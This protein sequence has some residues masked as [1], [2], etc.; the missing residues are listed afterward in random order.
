MNSPDS[1]KPF[2]MSDDR[3]ADG[4][5]LE[6]ESH[7]HIKR[8]LRK[9]GQTGASELIVVMSQLARAGLVPATVAL[10][11]NCEIERCIRELADEDLALN[12]NNQ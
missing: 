2:F 3:R 10:A 6:N 1:P 9:L 11:A 7:E 8:Y 4:V 12:H 5:A